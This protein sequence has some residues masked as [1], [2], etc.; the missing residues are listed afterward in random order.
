MIM[1]YLLTDVMESAAVMKLLVTNH[2]YIA[3]FYCMV[4]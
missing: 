1:K 4:V 2:L 3:A